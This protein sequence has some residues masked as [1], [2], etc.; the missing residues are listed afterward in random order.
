MTSH[1]PYIN[2]K[3]SRL[4]I[5]LGTKGQPLMFHLSVDEAKRLAELLVQAAIASKTIPSYS[6]ATDID[7][8]LARED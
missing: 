4:T 5:Y 6:S 3:A 2:V 8:P 7:F 1:D